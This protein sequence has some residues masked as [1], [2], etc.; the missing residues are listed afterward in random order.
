MRYYPNLN[1]FG[2]F[3]DFFNTTSSNTL[4]TD[5]REKDGM[6][7]LNMEVSGYKKEDIQIELSEGYLKVTA[8]QNEEKETNDGRIV[9]KERVSGTVSR[10]FYVG[11]NYKQSDITASFSNGELHIT[12]PTEVE[13]IEQS[14]QY[15][16]IQ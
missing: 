2:I 15:I 14:K 5:I 1:S 13:K 9:R 6:Y 4:R 12:L 8:N 16:S 7:E 10:S 3:D 11:D